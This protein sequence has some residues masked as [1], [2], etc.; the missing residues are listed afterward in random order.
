MQ[1]LPET[2]LGN[3]FNQQQRDTG[4]YQLIEAVSGSHIGFGGLHLFKFGIDLLRSQY[5]GASTSR[6]VLIER[7]DGTLARRLD[8]SGPT[9]QSIGSTDVA[10]FVQDR[11]QPNT[12]WSAEFGGRLDRDGI[13]D[14]F[15]MTPRI[16]LAMRLN[17]SGSA[18]LRGG[19]GLFFERT[20]SMAGTFDR[21]ENALDSRYASDGE[22]LLASAGSVRPR[23]GRPAD[24]AQP[25]AGHQL[26]P[27]ALQTVVVARRRHRPGRQPRTDR[28]FRADREM[29]L[30][31]G[32]CR[33]PA[34][35][36]TARPTSG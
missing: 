34:A 36:A 29:E 33:A 4:T 13:T 8:F 9:T 15:N 7:E 24:A 20:P 23:D 18:V 6:P 25:D 1:L 22:T 12:R 5:D 16:G 3:F 17:E 2:T 35:R 19:F 31:S 21:F 27:S 30:V 28:Q 11:F 10:L 14:R 26:R 32:S